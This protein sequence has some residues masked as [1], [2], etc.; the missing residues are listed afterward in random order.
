MS[1]GGGRGPS[2][3]AAPE[4]KESKEKKGPFVPFDGLLSPSDLRASAGASKAK[5]GLLPDSLFCGAPP[6]AA[7]SCW[8]SSCCSACCF[9][10]LF[11]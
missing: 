5:K 3:A 7:C 10:K 11:M 6:N 2:G 9:A 4:L 1:G 8:L